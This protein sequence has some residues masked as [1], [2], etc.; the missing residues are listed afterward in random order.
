MDA[1]ASGTSKRSPRPITIT[2]WNSN[3]ESPWNIV[4]LSTVDA[5]IVDRGTRITV[6]TS[7]SL[8]CCSCSRS[9]TASCSTAS[10]DLCQLCQPVSGTNHLSDTEKSLN[11]HTLNAIC[12]SCVSCVSFFKF[13]QRFFKTGL[14]FYKLNFNLKLPDTA[15]TDPSSPR[16]YWIL[17]QKFLTQA[18][19]QTWHKRGCFWHKHQIRTANRGSLTINRL[20]G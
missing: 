9:S 16:G 6:R 10:H 18:L 8:V 7:C 2:P 12:V 14:F 5:R 17:C 15:D 1:R 4:E 3:G 13:A 11:Y 19:T 20:D